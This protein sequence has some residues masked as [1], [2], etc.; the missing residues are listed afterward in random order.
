MDSTYKKVRTI[1]GVNTRVI[2]CKYLGPTNTQG[3]RIK[4]YDRHFKEAVVVS[5]NYEF[6]NAVEGAVYYLLACGFDVIGMNSTAIKE[7]YII[8]INNWDCEQRIT[9]G[10]TK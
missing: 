7:E 5:Y 9:N 10:V 1:C 2:T 4:L 8:I 3:S 6:S